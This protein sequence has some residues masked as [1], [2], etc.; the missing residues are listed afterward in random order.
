MLLYNVSATQLH[1]D[2]FWVTNT[3]VL[4][5]MQLALCSQVNAWLAFRMYILIATR[6]EHHLLAETAILETFGQIWLA[7]LSL[8]MVRVL[9]P[10]RASG[11]PESRIEPNIFLC[12]ICWHLLI[13]LRCMLSGWGEDVFTPHL[14]GSATGCRSVGSFPTG[15][16]QHQGGVQR[17][18]SFVQL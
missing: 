8:N 2:C 7:L 11:C 12:L 1:D 14:A 3:C 5:F 16:T 18:G 9:C 17:L 6:F 4:N 13:F 10:N 15:E